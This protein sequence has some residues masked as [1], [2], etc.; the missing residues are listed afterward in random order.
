M[1]QNG[2]EATVA[3]SRVGAALG[4]F[5][6]AA[7]A[8]EAQSKPPIF[9]GLLTA[10][11]GA[12]SQGD[13]RDWTFTPAVSMAV[14]DDHGLGAEVDLSY[15][16][17]Y[18]TAQF[19]DSSITTLMV[20]FVGMYPKGALRPYFTAGGGVVWLRVAY[21]P[22]SSLRE[23]DTAWNVGGGLVFMMNDALAFRG[24]VR[25]FRN[26]GQQSTIPLGENGDLDYLRTS[27]GISYTWPIR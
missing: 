7:T 26:F 21:D 1:A 4:V 5:V 19:A 25:Y 27:F 13:V 8:A 16:G 22:S 11:I 15:S 24:D 14:L 17:D 6:L 12:T 18:D 23:T 20:N 9:T 2:R 3:R 10:H